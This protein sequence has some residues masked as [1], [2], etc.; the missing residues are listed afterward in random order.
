MKSRAFIS[1]LLFATLFSACSDATPEKAPAPI[2]DSARATNSRSAPVDEIAISGPLV[3]ALTSQSSLR[4][5]RA[6][7]G[8]FV[9]VWKSGADNIHARLFHADGTAQG[10]VISIAETSAAQDARVAMD[11]NGAFVIV[12]RTLT[13]NGTGDDVLFQ[14]FDA[15]GRALSDAQSVLVQDG[16][17]DLQTAQAG[18][19]LQA[20][21]QEGPSELA[22][23]MNADGDFV[24]GWIRYMQLGLCCVGMNGLSL[25]PYGAFYVRPYFADGRPKRSPLQITA[26]QSR[27]FPALAIDAVGNFVAAWRHI[28]LA[29]SVSDIKL[30]HY[31][32]HGQVLS[33]AIAIA[34]TELATP[35]LAMN[36]AGEYVLV[37]TRGSDGNREIYSQRFR[38]DGSPSGPVQSVIATTSSLGRFVQAPALAMAVDASYSI[39]WAELEFID[40]EL[41][42]YEVMARCYGADGKASSPSPAKVNQHPLTDRAAQQLPAL[43]ALTALAYG[44]NSDVL[45]AWHRE[46][47]QIS[48]IRALSVNGCH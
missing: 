8:R 27:G 44:G 46:I 24:I 36:G 1:L 34:N 9:V 29:L 30:R 10:L 23:A 41:Y 6:A 4:V 42:R 39:A 21:L 33:P 47:Q 15:Q 3:S 28:N 13:T 45:I 26:G 16:L 43:P 19:L 14:R 35:A 25:S 11:A 22:L 18:A 7:D 17:I 31:S 38:P 12:W 40:N 48:E 32:E 2:D 20:R 5:A 37:W